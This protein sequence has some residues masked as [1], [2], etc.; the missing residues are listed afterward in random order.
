MTQAMLHYLIWD[1]FPWYIPK[2]IAFQQLNRTKN[3]QSLWLS[4]LT[5]EIERC[6]GWNPRVW[7]LTS[8][9]SENLRLSQHQIWNHMYRP[10]IDAV[11][12]KAIPTWSERYV[13][14]KRR[15]QTVVPFLK[16]SAFKLLLPKKVKRNHLQQFLG[17]WFWNIANYCWSK[18]SCERVEPIDPFFHRLRNSWRCGFL[19]SKQR[20]IFDLRDQFVF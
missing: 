11:S 12:K 8:E 14:W 5:V 15:C 4:S 6:Q 19:P 3:R 2:L 1:L 16:S 9:T 7:T 18:K 10:R 13:K 20:A 17:C